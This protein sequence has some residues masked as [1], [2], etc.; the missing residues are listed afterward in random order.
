MFHRSY[1]APGRYAVRFS[2]WRYVNGPLK[3]RA[4]LADRDQLEGGEPRGH[5]ATLVV[6]VLGQSSQSLSEMA[7]TLLNWSLSYLSK[8]RFV[9]LEKPRWQHPRLLR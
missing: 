7:S 9:N 4:L 3:R 1:L 5:D 2:L 8:R 6:A